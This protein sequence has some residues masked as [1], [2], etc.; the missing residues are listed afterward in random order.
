MTR[1]WTLSDDQQSE[2]LEALL[3]ILEIFYEFYSIHIFT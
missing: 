3:D 1:Y 2:V